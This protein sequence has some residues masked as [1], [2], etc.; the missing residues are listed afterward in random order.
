GYVG[1]CRNSWSCSAGSNRKVFMTRKEAIITGVAGLS[2]MAMAAQSA[3]AEE[4]AK[5]NPEVE[6]IQ[7][8]LKAHDEAMTNHNLDG[9]MKCLTEK[10]AIMGTG[11][12][13]V[14]VGPE[15]I[16]VAYEHFFEGFDKGQQ[17]FQYQFKI[18]GVGADMGWL[19]A[20][21]NVTGKKDGKDIAFPLNISMT[22]AKESGDWRIASMH[23]STLTGDEAKKSN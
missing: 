21:G 4:A 20:S 14:W 23:F 17:V 3:Q 22:V 9:V 1:L 19:M 8:L 12:G 7:A 13:E 11:P 16:K 18:G 15:E 6:K 5:A 2:A 10:A